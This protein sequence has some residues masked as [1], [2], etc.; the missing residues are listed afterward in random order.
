MC[1]ARQLQVVHHLHVSDILKGTVMYAQIVIFSFCCVKLCTVT[2]RN[3]H[4]RVLSVC[5]YIYVVT[6]TDKL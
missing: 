4:Q 2:E 6:Y 5:A 1:I 3:F